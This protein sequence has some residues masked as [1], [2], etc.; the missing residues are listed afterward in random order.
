[1]PKAVAPKSSDRSALLIRLDHAFSDYPGALARAAQYIVENPERVIH[2]SLAELSDY[3]RVGQASVVRLCRELGFE[4]FTQFKI[5][6]ASDLAV[7]KS[8]VPAGDGG[9]LD[10]LG[11]TADLLCTSINETRELIDQAALARIA[12]RLMR[13]VRI[14]LFGMGVSGMIG[15]LIGY[16]LL[17][18]GYHANAMRDAMLAHEVSGGLGPDTTSIAISQSGTTA[19]TVQFLKNAR[20]AGAF[21]VALTCHPKRALAKVAE[22]TLAMARLREPTYGGPVTDVPRAVLV[23]EALAIAIE[24]ASS[25]SK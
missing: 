21:T 23:A 10:P 17:R 7:R 6:L 15:E 16:R 5:A 2:Q 24:E 1:M 13:S 4:G 18:L 19:E 22:E 9:A 14:D 12:E 20:E 8:G 3:S 11:R 25:V